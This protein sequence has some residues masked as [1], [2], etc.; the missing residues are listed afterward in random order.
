MFWTKNPAP[1]MDRLSALDEMGYPYYFSVYA[2][3]LQEPDLEP[4][5]ADKDEGVKIFP[6]GFPGA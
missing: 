1:M 5:V 4:R 6:A 3:C 2:Y